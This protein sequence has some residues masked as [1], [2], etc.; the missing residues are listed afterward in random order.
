M[1]GKLRSAAALYVKSTEHVAEGCGWGAQAG[2]RLLRAA[3]QRHMAPANVAEKD[4]EAGVCRHG[5]PVAWEGT[6]TAHCHLGNHD[7]DR[8]FEEVKWQRGILHYAVEISLAEGMR[9]H[10]RAG[11]TDKTPSQLVHE[12]P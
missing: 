1:V 12:E 8:V 7:T 6:L 3:A 11:G 4:P 10:A 9:E 5:I 2:P